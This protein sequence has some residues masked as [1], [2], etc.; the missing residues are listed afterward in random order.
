MVRAPALLSVVVG[1][2]GAS[3]HRVSALLDW[4]SKKG[5]LT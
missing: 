5:V 3:P 4:E 2:D 1:L